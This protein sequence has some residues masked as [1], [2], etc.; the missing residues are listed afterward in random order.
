[1]LSFRKNSAVGGAFKLVIVEGVL[2]NLIAFCITEPRP[3][4]VPYAIFSERPRHNHCFSFW[5]SEH[6]MC[7]V[8]FAQAHAVFL[9]LSL[10]GVCVLEFCSLKYSPTVVAAP[11]NSYERQ[12]MVVFGMIAV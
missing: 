12:K 4:V 2:E 5:L 1:V 6:T 3:I 7:W 9:F 11:L 8:D 10:L